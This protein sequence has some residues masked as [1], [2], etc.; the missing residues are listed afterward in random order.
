MCRYVVGAGTGAGVYTYV[1]G[2]LKRTYNAPY[3]RTV[4]GSHD[5]LQHLKVT[6]IGKKAAAL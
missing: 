3:D 1:S 2:D 5:A 6:V 4:K